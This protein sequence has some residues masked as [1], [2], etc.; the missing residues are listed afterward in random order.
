MTI[1]ERWTSGKSSRRVYA[2]DGAKVSNPLGGGVAATAT[3]WKEMRLVT[4]AVLSARGASREYE[5]TRYLDD[6]GRLV[7]ET[8]VPGRLNSRKSLY[9]KVK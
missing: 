7:V 1:E 8:T 6:K 5:E 3:A 9:T 4:T 2:L